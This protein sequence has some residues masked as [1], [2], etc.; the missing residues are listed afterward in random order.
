MRPRYICLG[1]VALLAAMAP[2]LVLGQDDYKPNTDYSRP[3]DF[4]ARGAAVNVDRSAEAFDMIVEGITYTI[5]ADRAAVQLKGGKFITIRD[6]K[7]NARV[8]VTGEQLSART[9]LA[10][11]VTVLDE[12]GSYVDRASQG[13]RPND[14]VDTRGYVTRVDPRFGEI[15]IRTKLGN[16]VVLVKA[17]SVIRRYIYVADISEVNEGDDIGVVGTVDR[18]GRIVAERV[19][20]SVSASPDERATYYPT[21]KGYRP[22]AP[23]SLSRR[24]DVIEG[25]VTSPASMFDRSL[26]VA[27]RYGERKVDVPKDADVVISGHPASVHDLIKGDKVRAIGA[28]S[29][30]TLVASR[31]ESG[32][33]PIETAVEQPSATAPPSPPP[34]LESPRPNSLTGRIVDIDYVKFELSI[35]WEMKDIKIDAADAAVTRKGSTRRFSDLKKGDKVEVKGD[36]VGDVL[37]ATT[38]DVTE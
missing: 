11:T 23:S 18:D 2:A 3:G 15:D 33:K 22:P 32:E 19:Q 6:L 5:L 29:G 21:G 17:G 1:L 38:V 12:S 31:I 26:A 28:W 37:K 35:D 8:E 24:E 7:D 27:T 34:V 20:V 36:W 9:V 16:Y 30:S 4:R 13:Y 14:H 25:T 10:A